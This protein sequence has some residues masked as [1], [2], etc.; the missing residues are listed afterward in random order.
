MASPLLSGV[1][2]AGRAVGGGLASAGEAVGRG[3]ENVATLGERDNPGSTRAYLLSQLHALD[4]STPEGAANLATI[5]VPGGQGPRGGTAAQEALLDA[6]YESSRGRQVAFLPNAESARAGAFNPETGATR[7]GMP[8]L[9]SQEGDVALA[10]NPEFVVRN[11][12]RLRKAQAPF[13]ILG[14]GPNASRVGG[15]KDFAGYRA[16]FQRLGWPVHTEP[17]VLPKQGDFPALSAARM[18]AIVR[19]LQASAIRGRN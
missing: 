18:A 17:G 16:L 5:L 13:P 10:A 15:S 7:L 4:P 9:R 8:R 11:P 19:I 3:V 14:T 1:L 2:S 6:I 12:P